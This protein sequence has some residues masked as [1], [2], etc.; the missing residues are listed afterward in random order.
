MARCCRSTVAGWRADMRMVGAGDAILTRNG[1]SH[2]LKQVGAGDLVIF[3]VHR[4][5]AARP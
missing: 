3:I 4:R 5:P 1:D 2:A